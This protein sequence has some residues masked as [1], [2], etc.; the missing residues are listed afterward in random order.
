MNYLDYV[1]P[2]LGIGGLI[3]IVYFTFR[4]GLT[5]LQKQ[6]NEALRERV[7]VLESKIADLEKEK[8]IH[9][10]IIDTITSALKQRGMVVTID[11][12]MVTISDKTSSTHRKRTITTTQAASVTK[13]EEE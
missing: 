7:D 6:V 4:S 5:A 2:A 1:Y 3:G 12:D 8:A 9:R 11:G 13:K 10:H